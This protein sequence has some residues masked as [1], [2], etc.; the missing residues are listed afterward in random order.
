MGRWKRP[1]LSLTGPIILV[2]VALTGG[3][4]LSLA[5]ALIIHPNFGTG[6]RAT[7]G[8]TPTDFVTALYVGG[9]SLSFRRR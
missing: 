5:T 6:I 1:F 9:S 3:L 2:L 4:L 7:Q 8:A